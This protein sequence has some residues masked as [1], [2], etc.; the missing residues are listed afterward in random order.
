MASF[1]GK[2]CKELGQPVPDNGEHEH[3]QLDTNAS[4]CVG[5]NSGIAFVDYHNFEMFHRDADFAFQAGL[6]PLNR[7]EKYFKAFLK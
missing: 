2:I 7:T 1:V 6:P 3:K 4:T 5:I